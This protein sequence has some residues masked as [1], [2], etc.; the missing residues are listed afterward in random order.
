LDLVVDVG[1]DDDVEEKTH[2]DNLGEVDKRDF[3][4]LLKIKFYILSR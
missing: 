4:F 2:K 3:L 1:A